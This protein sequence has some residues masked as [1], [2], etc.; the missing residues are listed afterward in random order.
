MSSSLEEKSG[1]ISA[2]GTPIRREKSG[3]MT[4]N[5]IME[6]AENEPNGIVNGIS[7]GI[8]NGSPNG[9]VGGEEGHVGVSGESKDGVDGSSP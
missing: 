7:N 1:G 2:P 3:T 4:P 8:V 6:K 9:T 5:G